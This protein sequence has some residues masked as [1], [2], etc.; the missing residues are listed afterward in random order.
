M[1][2]R[3]WRHEQSE[4]NKTRTRRLR[5]KEKKPIMYYLSLSVVR[6]LQA[7]IARYKSP[8]MVSPPLEDIARNI[9]QSESL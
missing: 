6:T 5:D 9:S 2:A 7:N 3:G 8:S 1:E 4:G